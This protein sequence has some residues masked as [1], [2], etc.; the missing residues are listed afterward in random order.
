MGK[1]IQVNLGKIT[2]KFFGKDKPLDI[3]YSGLKGNVAVSSP[4]FLYHF[5]NVELL[6]I[7]DTD[8]IY[9]ELYKSKLSSKHDVLVDKDT[10]TYDPEIIDELFTISKFVIYSDLSIVFT[11]NFKLNDDAFIK[12]FK[13]LYHRNAPELFSNIEIHYQKDDFDIFEKI[14]SF[15]RLVEVELINIRK[16]NPC[17]KPTFEKI[18]ALLDKEKTD[19]LYA[20]FKSEKDAG[21]ARDLESHIMSGISIADSGYG[22]SVILGQNT[23]GNFEKIKLKDRAIRKR[24]DEKATTE[25]ARFAIF[26][27]KLF[28]KYIF[29]EDELV[30]D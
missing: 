6:K 24:V 18:E 13:I 15:S 29:S 11:S 22:D 1:T 7:P 2:H 30:D 14:N 25:K 28:G 19:V 10:L 5:N 21:L 8:A 23:D 17:P 3:I 12:Y 16:S 4:S 27:H 9:G 26:V 20:K